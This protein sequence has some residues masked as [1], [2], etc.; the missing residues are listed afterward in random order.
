[1]SLLKYKQVGE[2]DPSFYA[3]LAQ[4]E[5][6]GK[7]IK[8]PQKGASAAGIYQFTKGTWK[9][10]TEKMGLNYTADD[11]YDPVKQQKVIERFT[12]D[13]EQAI[14]NTLGR[15]PNST[16]L[17][18]AHF[19][20][21]G[22][23][24]KFLRS[25]KANPDARVAPTEAE[26]KYNKG[27]FLNKSGQLR[28]NKEVYN[29]LT[30][31][32]EGGKKKVEPDFYAQ[33]VD[34]VAEVINIESPITQKV[35]N[36]DLSKEGT[37]FEKSEDTSK[38]VEAEKVLSERTNELNL[39]DEMAN[40]QRNNITQQFNAPQM[41]QT[42]PQKSIEQTFAE[43][44][45][46]VDAPIARGGGNIPVS[47]KG[48]YDYPMQDV[49]VPTSNGRITMSDVRYPILGISLETGE[50]RMMMPNEEHNFINTKYVYE[51][52][53]LKKYFNK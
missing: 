49:I 26:L 2:I 9:A 25:L 24:N 35:I 46:F 7:S 6:G 37:T 10:V 18:A 23:A 11:R 29:E 1:M 19:L 45:N 8:N 50:Q 36:F 20:G 17:Y 31:R 53:Q 14:T 21:A 52:P 33:P 15:K 13:N 32:I 28:T 40:Q 41:Q 42:A 48:V 5:S 30:R 43:V 47:S 12:K 39:I 38:E 44:S 22:G 51:I 27:V 3:K 16:E 4:A 34:A